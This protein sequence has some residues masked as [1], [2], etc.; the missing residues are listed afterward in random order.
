MKCD[1]LL[2]YT[3]LF[4]H[5]QDAYSGKKD[6]GADIVEPSQDDHDTSMMAAR[7]RSC[8][9]RSNGIVQH[10][11]GWIIYHNIIKIF[12]YIMSCIIEHR[13]ILNLKIGY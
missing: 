11:K 9:C 8:F 3:N 2:R 5:T 10:P 1:A 7:G 12:L 6:I 4:Y 13:T